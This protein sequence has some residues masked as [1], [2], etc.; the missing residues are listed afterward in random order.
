MTAGTLP[1][2]P[3]WPQVTQIECMSG[4][5]LTLSAPEKAQLIEQRFF[6]ED[7]H[8]LDAKPC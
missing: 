5:V 6:G 4:K 7:G 3:K 1:V 8:S 2:I